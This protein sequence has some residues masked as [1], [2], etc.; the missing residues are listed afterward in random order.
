MVY[1]II[2]KANSGVKSYNAYEKLN[3]AILCQNISKN[4][5][6][7]NEQNILTCFFKY[8]W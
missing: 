4:K 2:T 5:E 1:Q 8:K 3:N 6:Y 7:S